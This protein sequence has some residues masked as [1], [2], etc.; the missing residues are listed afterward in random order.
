MS[1]DELM[2]RVRDLHSA[3]EIVEAID[4]TGGQIAGLD[5][6]NWRYELIPWGV[7]F[8]YS[9]HGNPQRRCGPDQGRGS[10]PPREGETIRCIVLPVD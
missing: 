8:I 4:G 1:P 9:A 5:L 6:A 7:R 2:A 3:A 10:R